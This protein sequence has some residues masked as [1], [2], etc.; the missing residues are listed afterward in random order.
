MLCLTCYLFSH[1]NVRLQKLFLRKNKVKPVI[2]S[3]KNDDIVGEEDKELYVERI[4]LETMKLRF[5]MFLACC[6]I[7]IPTTAVFPSRTFLLLL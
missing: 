5:V 4:R 3:K 2:D 6:S 7:T 1:W